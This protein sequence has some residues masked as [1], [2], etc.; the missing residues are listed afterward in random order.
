MINQIIQLA[1]QFYWI[2]VFI[3][4]LA[5]AISGITEGYSLYNVYYKIFETSIYAIIAAIIG[6]SAIESIS[7]LLIYVTMF[8]L[9]RVGKD[10]AFIIPFL[11]TGTA[12]LLFIHNVSIPVSIEGIDK[13]IESKHNID[14]EQRAIEKEQYQAETNAINNYNQETQLLEKKYKSDSIAVEKKYL[15]KYLNIQKQSH[16]KIQSYQDRAFVEQ[17]DYSTSIQRVKAKRKSQIK[18]NETDKDIALSTLYQDFNN[19]KNANFYK[20]DS[21]NTAIQNYAIHK[22]SHRVGEKEYSR[23]VITNSFYFSIICLA[24]TFFFNALSKI[25]T[26]TPLPDNVTHEAKNAKRNAKNNAKNANNVKDCK[27]CKLP[28]TPKRKTKKFCSDACRVDYHK[29]NNSS[30]IE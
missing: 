25:K 18:D 30:T 10:L 1:K 24:I 12:S 6:V 23:S 27:Y 19:A 21:V 8:S 15:I 7:A 29:N 4:I 13:Y 20:R 28:F 9:I 17:K 16:Q 11:L 5:I 2:T 22:I 3:S 26:T 14:A